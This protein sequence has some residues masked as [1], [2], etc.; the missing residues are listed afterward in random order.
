MNRPPLEDLKQTADAV[1]S[2]ATPESKAAY[3]DQAFELF[4]QETEK[5]A[6]AYW[7]LQ[8]KFEAV[9]LEL[10]STNEKLNSKVAELDFANSYLDS[11][12]SQMSQGLLFIDLTGTVTTY[13]KAAEHFLAH[14]AEEILLRSFWNFFPDEL[15]GFS[16]RLALGEKKAPP[17]TFVTIKNKDNE[18]REIE[19]STNLIQQENAQGLIILLRDI[20]ELRRLQTLAAR[21]DRL[22][23]LG[24]MAAMV[25]HE[26][27]NPL[28]GI[29]GFASLLERDLK[30]QP[31]LAKM[32]G[33]II[34]GTDTLNRLV[35]TI[36]NYSRPIQPRLETTD[37]VALMHELVEHI[38]A[39]PSFNPNIHIHIHAKKQ[40]VA[41]PVDPAILKSA[42]LNL[43]VN[44]IQAMPQGGQI[45]LNVGKEKGDAIIQV[46]DTGTG[47][48]EENMEKLFSPFFTTRS[49]GNG[50]G[51]AEVHKVVQAHA[52]TIE[53]I[54]ALG[55][56]TTFTLKLPLHVGT[57]DGN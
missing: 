39:D 18:Y 2:A 32:A 3:L 21:H 8:K 40:P 36:L 47:I 44:S 38:Q 24:E 22:K 52:G 17:L 46:T 11:I 56:G 35:N 7:N 14:K 15:F 1:K 6:G 4:K 51:L 29:K 20:T 45:N 50:F 30:Q 53:A 25:A 23:E 55:K 31:E 19:A 28:G 27:R 10:Q 54:S 37:L 57:K 13:N 41:A 48:P 26:I 42:I 9:N 33:Y 5:L 34:E 16:L 12:L 43:L 49:D